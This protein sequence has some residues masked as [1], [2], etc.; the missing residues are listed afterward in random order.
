VEG[1]CENGSGT[2]GVIIVREVLQQLGDY[3]LM[4]D[5]VS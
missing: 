3:Q 1:S 5:V 2:L 4:I